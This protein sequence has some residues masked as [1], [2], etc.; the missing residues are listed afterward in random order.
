MTDKEDIF[1]FLCDMDS[2]KMYH[3]H[4]SIGG[5]T[6]TIHICNDCVDKLVVDA[7]AKEFWKR[8]NDANEVRKKKKEDGKE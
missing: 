5:G 1:C 7:L 8:I 2:E 6:V 3:K 4:F